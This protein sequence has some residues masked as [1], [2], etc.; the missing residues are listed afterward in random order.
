MGLRNGAVKRRVTGLASHG[1][2]HSLPYS[3]PRMNENQEI[4]DQNPTRTPIAMGQVNLYTAQ[5]ATSVVAVMYLSNFAKIALSQA[6]RELIK[7]LIHIQTCS[8]QFQFLGQ[9][10]F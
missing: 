7:E 5:T 2:G 1:H 9:L 8:N 4:Q 6:S 3:R 10:N